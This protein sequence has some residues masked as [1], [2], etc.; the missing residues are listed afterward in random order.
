MSQLSTV[1]ARSAW[2]TVNSPASVAIATTTVSAGCDVSTTVYVPLSPSFSVSAVGA[3]PESETGGRCG[4][5]SN[6][7]VE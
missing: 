4:R 5:I 6:N 2:S 3:M 1:N 7:R